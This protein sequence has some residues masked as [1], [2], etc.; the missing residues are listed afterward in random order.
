MGW[1]MAA[2]VGSMSVFALGQIGAKLLTGVIIDRRN[3]RS[4]LPWYLLPLATAF[5]LPGLIGAGWIIPVVMGL[6][7]ISAGISATLLGVLWPELFGSRYLG[8][9]RAV[10][11]AAMVASTA[12]SPVLTGVLIDRGIGF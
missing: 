2:M 10:T 4:L 11:Y 5:L 9:V 6:M 7:G 1:S 3:A 12:A 8:E